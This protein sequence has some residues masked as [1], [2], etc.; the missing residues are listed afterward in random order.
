M[1]EL[2]APALAQSG[3][4]P[5]A[6]EIFG[7]LQRELAPELSGKNRSNLAV[8]SI[9]GRALAIHGAVLND[10]YH[11]GQTVINDYGRPFEPG[12]NA[13][14]GYRLEADSGR[15]EL[16]VRGEFQ[17]APAAMGYSTAV[18]N[19]LADLDQTPHVPQSDIPQGRIAAA[20]NVRLLEANLSAHVLGH[21]ISF[22][23]DDAWLGPAQGGSMAWSNN[24][25]NIYSFRINRIEPLFVPGLS[26]LVGIFRYDFF[27]GSLKGHSYPNDP[28]IHSTKISFKPTPDLE[29]GFQRSV[30]WGGKGHVPVT[31]GTFLRSFFSAAGVSPAVKFSREDPGARF[32]TFDFTWRTPWQNHLI[33]L[34]TDSLVHDNVFPVSNPARAGLRPGVY[35]ARL[36]RL[37]HVDLRVE[38]ASTDPQ[39]PGSKSGEFLYYEAAQKQGYTNRGQILGDW[40]G[41]QSKGGQAWLTWHRDAQQSVQ[42]E[43]RMAKAARDFIPG[44]TTQQDVSLHLVLRPAGQIELKATGQAELWRAPLIASGTQR[45]VSGSFQLTWYPKR[46]LHKSGR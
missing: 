44:G 6:V 35:I 1:L 40:I 22:G 8:D 31:V 4:D 46:G 28:W 41:R 39:D 12:W 5:E 7:A 10:S 24:A 15:L 33:T 37:Q 34:Y 3:A 36:P 43:C 14:S 17:H 16:S 25:E 23:K 9:Y 27:V 19:T 13:V 42:L 38:G 21:Q 30:I 18:A 32:S 26:S 11:L 45:D 20:N 29:F 2:S